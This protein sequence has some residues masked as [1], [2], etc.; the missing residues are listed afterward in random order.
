M[1]IANVNHRGLGLALL[2][3][4]LSSFRYWFGFVS[5]FPYDNKHLLFDFMLFMTNNWK[6]L[7]DIRK[8]DS[9]VQLSVFLVTRS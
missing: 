2:F 8:S 9:W 1:G 4:P 5:S 3:M 6:G 7:D